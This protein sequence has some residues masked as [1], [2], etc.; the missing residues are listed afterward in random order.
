[1]SHMEDLN[2]LMSR[3]K[4]SGDKGSIKFVTSLIAAVKDGDKEA[5]K[6]IIHFNKGEANLVPASVSKW[7]K[8][9]A[10]MD[11]MDIQELLLGEAKKMSE[12]DILALIK[13]AL[14]AALGGDHDNA[15]I[16]YSKLFGMGLASSNL[17]ARVDK[18]FTDYLAT[19]RKIN[20]QHGT[21]AEEDARL[22]R[23]LGM[24]KEAIDGSP[25]DL[26]KA[27]TLVNQAKMLASITL[28]TAL[29]SQWSD[30]NYY[31]KGVTVR[32]PKPNLNRGFQ[33]VQD[34]RSYGRGGLADSHEPDGDDIQEAADSFLLR[35]MEKAEDRACMHFSD[36]SC[37]LAVKI[38]DLLRAGK[39]EEGLKM[40][41][42]PKN[43]GLLPI[44]PTE[45]RSWFGMTVSNSY[46]PS[47]DT[48]SE[49]EWGGGFQGAADAHKQVQA[50]LRADYNR[51]RS[52]KL[53]WIVQVIRGEISK[54]KFRKLAGISFDEIMTTRY[55]NWYVNQVKRMSKK[56]LAPVNPP[57][58]AAPTT[59]SAD[60]HEKVEI[61]GRTRAY[62]NTVM[63]LEQAR[64]LRGGKGTEMQE[65]K[66]GG[67]YDDGSGKGAIIPAPVDY[68]FHEAMKIVEKYRTL[69][70][71]KK[72]LFGAP[73]GK[74]EDLEAAVAMKGG[75]FSMAET[76]MSPKQKEYRAF[77][78]KALK[79]FGH[80][81][82]ADMDDGEK[83]KFFNWIEKNWK[84]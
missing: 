49:D 16:L 54:Q 67:L 9:S 46:Q 52:Q 76:E 25:Q 23:L 8:E 78:A 11:D 24:A 6:G 39:K 35:R 66:F 22:T 34:P 12:E 71:K 83:K 27:R 79:K 48:L 36:E 64:R 42:D 7:I 51:E 68:N 84:G 20:F 26:R 14:Q 21:T 57:A 41:Q 38:G 62:R 69:R 59:E 1:M 75:K 58:P 10:D 44:I 28:N 61:D 80:K 74:M 15:R 72:T 47:G 37:I 40:L 55:R 60:I 77:F 53:K 2:A 81:S 29:R 45:V 70:E 63:R 43:K 82:P 33:G 4:R 73:K 5:A 3:V 56:A 65:N 17:G 50:G 30:L 31:L 32:K 18:A 13:K 19:L